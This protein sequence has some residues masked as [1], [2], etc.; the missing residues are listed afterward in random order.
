MTQKA[1]FAKDDADGEDGGVFELNKGGLFK[2]KTK[3]RDLAKICNLLCNLPLLPSPKIGQVNYIILYL[4]GVLY[5]TLV[6]WLASATL[7]LPEA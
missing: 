7:K 2:K 6:H 1:A 3:T 5:A 4:A